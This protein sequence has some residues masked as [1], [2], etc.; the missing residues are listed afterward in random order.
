M[1]RNLI[2]A[3]ALLTTSLSTFPA[4]AATKSCDNSKQ[5][6][7]AQTTDQQHNNKDK[8]A[9]KDHNDQENKVDF[10]IYG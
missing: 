1:K 4:F 2:L 6:S 9:K 8:K 3:L 10:S 7:S 5:E